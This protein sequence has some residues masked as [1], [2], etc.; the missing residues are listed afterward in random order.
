MLQDGAVEI[1]AE[2]ERVAYYRAA[3][4]CLKFVESRRPTGRRLGA[5]A[6]AAWKSFRGDLETADRIDLLL[7]DADAEWPAAFGAR[8]VFDLRATA[9]DEAFGAEWAPLDPVDA[10]ELWRQMAGQRGPDS[11]AVAARAISEAWKLSPSPANVGAVAPSE[12]LILVGPGAVVAAIEAFAAGTDLDWADQVAVI[13]T[14]P[15]HRH[16]AAAG[17]ALLNATKAT[18][19][20]SADGVPAELSGRVVLSD[21]ADAADRAAAEPF[22]K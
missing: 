14:P 5:D 7:R 17:A 12:K 13:A 11:P 1:A 10:E 18:R 8:T 3:L 9:E 4:Q 2:G 21:D 6:D 16:L 15:G 19:L 22:Q 20:F